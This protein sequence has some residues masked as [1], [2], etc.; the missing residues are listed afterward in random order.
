MKNWK[1][2]AAREAAGLTALTL[3]EMAGIGENKIYALERGRCRLKRD[4]AAKLADALGVPRWELA[5]QWHTR[6]AEGASNREG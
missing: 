5:P 6:P 2:K 4:D 3:G 1:L